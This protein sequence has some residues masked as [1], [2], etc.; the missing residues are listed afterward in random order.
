MRATLYLQVFIE[1]RDPDSNR[2]HHDFQWRDLCS[3]MFLVVQN[4]LQI[5]QILT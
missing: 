1:W 2:G 4:Y 3:Q 5:S